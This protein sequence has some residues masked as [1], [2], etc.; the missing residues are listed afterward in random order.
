MKKKKVS[1]E[2]LRKLNEQTKRI[3]LPIFKLEADILQ[4]VRS[5]DD[6][7][8]GVIALET[9]LEDFISENSTFF[10]DKKHAATIEWLRN[11]RIRWR[12]LR[13][14]RKQKRPRRTVSGSMMGESD[15]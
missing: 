13:S 12:K 8:A 2:E 15:E 9:V 6:K 3:W 4:L 11:E 7:I 10:A 14:V 1:E 5:H